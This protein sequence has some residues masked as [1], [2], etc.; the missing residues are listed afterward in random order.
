VGLLNGLSGCGGG[1]PSNTPPV[2]NAGSAQAAIARATVTL[3][4]STSADA[5]NDPL[6][7]AWALTNRPAGSAT[8]LV[9]PTSP[10]PTFVPDVAGTYTGTL[11]VSDGKATSNPAT[12]SVTVSAYGPAT[13]LV[14]ESGN[15]QDLLQH[16]RA[17]VFRVKV[18]DALGNPV[19]GIPVTFSAS[20]ATAFNPPI[21]VQTFTDGIATATIGDADAW[22]RFFHLAGLQQIRAS[23]PGIPQLTF[24][25]TV[26]PSA[27]PYDGRYYCNDSP[28]AAIPIRIENGA[29]LSDVAVS[30]ATVNESTGAINVN[31]GSGSA[32]TGY[33]GQILIVRNLPKLHFR[34]TF[35][36]SKPM[37]LQPPVIPGTLVPWSPLA[38][39]SRRRAWR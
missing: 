37:G 33:T 31:R 7:Y 6:T 20:V 15:N 36:A 9:G 4:G 16:Q 29:V 2:A 1:S 12:F 22:I 23:A 14:A 17:D 34:R 28:F 5:D 26:R 24:Q 21:A 39:D 32:R 38:F 27:H 10:K 8:Q 25:V 18:Q 30:A 19:P 13:A 35:G 11:T 3:D